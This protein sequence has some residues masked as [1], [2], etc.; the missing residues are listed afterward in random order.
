[1]MAITIMISIKVKPRLDLRI[2]YLSLYLPPHDT[3]AAA[4]GF[5]QQ[6]SDTATGV[7]HDHVGGPVGTDDSTQGR[8]PPRENHPAGDRVE[9]V[10]HAVTVGV[11]HRVIK[12]LTVER[13]HLDQFAGDRKSVV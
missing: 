5:S 3:A 10:E 11:E 6:V 8:D 1:M 2:P 12:H 7:V 9:A 4:D 13:I